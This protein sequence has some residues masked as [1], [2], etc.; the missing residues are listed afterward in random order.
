MPIGK[1][2]ENHIGM[3]SSLPRMYVEDQ[4]LDRLRQDFNN[5]PWE[6]REIHAKATEVDLTFIDSHAK[7]AFRHNG[8]NK[9]EW[10]CYWCHDEND[11]LYMIE[12]DYDNPFR[13]FWAKTIEHTFTIK[14]TPIK[15]RAKDDLNYYT[16]VDWQIL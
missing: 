3:I 2:T 15:H 7:R 5:S 16:L 1:Y 14:G 13:N 4:L 9:D 11:R 10:L 6:E 12:L 8:R